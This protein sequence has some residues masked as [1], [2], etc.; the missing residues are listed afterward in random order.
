LAAFHF[1]KDKNGNSY[2]HLNNNSP[3]NKMYNFVYEDLIECK[4][5]GIKII[6]MLGGAGEA[7]NYMFSNKQRYSEC[8]SLL[9]NYIKNKE[10][11]FDG[12]DFD[13]EE[14][15]GLDNTIKLIS[16]LDKL[17][18][19]NFLFT[20]APVSFGL[21]DNCIGM[22][23]FKYTDLLNSS[24]GKRINYLNGQFYNYDNIFNNDLYTSYN[25]C[26]KNNI[27]KQLLVI[28]VDNITDYYY[29]EIKKIVANGQ[30]S[31][32]YF[33]EYIHMPPDFID[34]I[35]TIFQKNLKKTCIIS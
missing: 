16:D 13:I 17:L 1:G 6:L 12:I 15:I 26:L 20:M 34:K 31:G 10:N 3:Y 4:K 35:Y 30:I 9:V 5:K 19:T 22:G 21:E 32:V 8:L 29:D 23:G 18:P 2:I 7:Y 11:I 14:N 24:V 25:N 28:G 33:W 27:P